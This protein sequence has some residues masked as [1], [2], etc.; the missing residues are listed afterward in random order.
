MSLNNLYSEI[1][2]FQL[3]SQQSRMWLQ[4]NPSQLKSV[5]TF[6]AQNSIR[7]NIFCALWSTFCLILAHSSSSRDTIS[8]KSSSSSLFSIALWIHE[9]T[10]E[11]L[12]FADCI[13]ERSSASA[14]I[15][16]IPFNFGTSSSKGIRSHL[17]FI[18]KSTIKL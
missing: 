13:A 1:L 3:T 15:L 12:L 8:M 11:R 6:F 17:D 2:I 4:K 5:N 16:C 7:Q 14:C 18:L 9:V 10:T